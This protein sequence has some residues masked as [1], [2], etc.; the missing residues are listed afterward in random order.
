[1]YHASQRTIIVGDV[2]GCLSELKELLTK[3]QFKNQI[4]RLIFVGDLINKGPDSFGVLQLVARELETEVVMG[5]HEISFLRYIND[6][7]ESHEL[8]YVTQGA[9]VAKHWKKLNA[10]MSADSSF[11][12]IDWLQQ[13]P[14]YIEEE[15]FIVVHAGVAP[16]MTLAETPPHILTKIRNWD[17]V[18]KNL[19][20]P[21]DPAWYE[22]YHAPKLIIF[23]HW[24]EKGLV[25]RNNAI[26]LDTGC[27]YGKK[28]S[29]LVLPE[30]K[31]Y[32][33]DAQQEYVPIK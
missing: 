23:G 20:Q 17:G 33:V 14:F 11:D 19:K 25:W 2:H 6:T 21:K 32:Q 29:A 16:T 7:L 22:L 8:R 18:G 28:L 30:K 5:N 9:K 10:E 31:L 4:D 1:M 13:R 3:V 24:A 15:Q 26:G 12:W 27:V